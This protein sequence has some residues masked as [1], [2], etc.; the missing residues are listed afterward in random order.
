MWNSIVSVPDHCLFINFVSLASTRTNWMK[1]YIYIY[2]TGN[3][4][5]TLKSLKTVTFNWS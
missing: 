5:F 1:T 2:L 4:E 3:S